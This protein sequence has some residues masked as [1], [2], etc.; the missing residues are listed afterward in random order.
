MNEQEAEKVVEIMLEADGSCSWCGN[1]LVNKFI[2]EFP[3]FEVLAKKIFY[4]EH[5]RELASDED[6]NNDKF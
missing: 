6:M 3:Q 1:K 4:E 2:K 5:R